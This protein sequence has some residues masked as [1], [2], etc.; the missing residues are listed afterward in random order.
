MSN[1]IRSSVNEGTGY[2]YRLYQVST[3]TSSTNYEVGQARLI[4]DVSNTPSHESYIWSN[5][6]D[7]GY[8]SEGWSITAV[9]SYHSEE[10]VISLNSSNRYHIQDF[11]P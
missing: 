2:Y 4:Y 8:S 1:D 7:D 10:F 5:Q 11:M 9:N 3:T 6:T